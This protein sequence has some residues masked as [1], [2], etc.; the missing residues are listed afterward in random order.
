M[1]AAG[2]ACGRAEPTGGCGT[3]NERQW[4]KMTLPN[5]L[6]R[7]VQLSQRSDSAVRERVGERAPPLLDRAIDRAT[8]ALLEQQ[9]HDGHWVFELEAD[10]TISSEYILLRHY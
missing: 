8:N 1:R 10:T 5:R 4:G 2:A 9:K 3:S 6:H 7:Q